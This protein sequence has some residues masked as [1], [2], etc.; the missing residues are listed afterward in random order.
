MANMLVADNIVTGSTRFVDRANTC[1]SV[2]NSACAGRFGGPF[3]TLAQGVSV[4][5]AG[6][7]V[8]IRPGHYNERM[9]LTKAVTFRP[10][11]GDGQIGKP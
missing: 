6:D 5:S 3:P 8:L 1:G 11:R 9:T 7:I 2:G 10:T 4:A